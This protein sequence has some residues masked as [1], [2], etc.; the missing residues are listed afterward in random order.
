[1]TFFLFVFFSPLR[2]TCDFFIIICCSRNNESHL[3]G[4]TL[5]S[6]CLFL[7]VNEN[8]GKD[9]FLIVKQVTPEMITT[10]RCISADAMCL[11]PEFH[12]SQDFKSKYLDMKNNYM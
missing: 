2:N 9:L 6:I 5:G 8:R 12:F 10:S 4:K 7:P 3:H 1:V 11:L